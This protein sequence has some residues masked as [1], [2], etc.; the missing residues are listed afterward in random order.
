M[1][2]ALPMQIPFWS[3]PFVAIVPLVIIGFF[4]SLPIGNMAHFG[5]FIA[6][7]VYGVYLR[8]KYAKK[9]QLLNRM[10]K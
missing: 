6:G 3:L 4:V 2:F 9:V 5:G 10:I 7:A 1:K 8:I